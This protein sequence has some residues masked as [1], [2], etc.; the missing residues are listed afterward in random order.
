MAPYTQNRVFAL[1]ARRLNQRRRKQGVN[2]G[3]ERAELTTSGLT[4][5]KGELILVVD[6][7]RQIRDM[8]FTILTRNRYRVILAAD[9]AEAAVVFA[10]RAAEIRLVIT[11]LHMP[12]LDGATLGR[13]LRRINPGTRMLVISG[14]ASALGN[15]PGYEPE[16][17]ADAFLH[18]PFKPE[19]LLAKVHELLHGGGGG[20][21]AP[22]RMTG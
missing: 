7:E 3:R 9:G 2:V 18:K 16:E 5:G 14:M 12:N 20:S 11:D 8:T 13:A 17:F 19:L 10:Q 22:W 21:G 1:R 6:D 4:P 15:R